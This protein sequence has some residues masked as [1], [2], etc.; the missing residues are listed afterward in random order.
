[1]I[2]KDPK[3]VSKVPDDYYVV[4]VYQNDNTVHVVIGVTYRS[5]VY[6]MDKETGDVRSIKIPPHGA[7]LAIG[8]NDSAYNKSHYIYLSKK[9]RELRWTSRAKQLLLGRRLSTG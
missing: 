3:H 9:A 1:M 8:Q 2:L 5:R 6:Y 7:V 4:L